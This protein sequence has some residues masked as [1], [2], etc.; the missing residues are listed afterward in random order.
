MP[1]LALINNIIKKANLN[2]FNYEIIDTKDTISDEDNVNTIL[3]SKKNSRR[4]KLS[5]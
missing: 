5:D 1:K 3:R 2:L 4:I